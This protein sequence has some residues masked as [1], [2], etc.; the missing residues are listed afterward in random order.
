MRETTSYRRAKGEVVPDRLPT[1]TARQTPRKRV[2]DN[3][4]HERPRKRT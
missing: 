4:L 1:G 3:G 2:R